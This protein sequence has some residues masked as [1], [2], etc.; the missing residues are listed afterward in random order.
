MKKIE[1]EFL[2][3]ESTKDFMYNM[4]EQILEDLNSYCECQIPISKK[5]LNSFFFLNLNLK[6]FISKYCQSTIIKIHQVQ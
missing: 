2:S 1:S 4:I 5:N 6:R 3:N